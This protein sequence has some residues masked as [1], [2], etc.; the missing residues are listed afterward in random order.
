M[1]YPDYFALVDRHRSRD[2]DDVGA[3]GWT[4]STAVDADGA[5]HIGL[6]ERPT[7]GN[8]MAGFSRQSPPHELLGPL[9]EE[10]RPTKE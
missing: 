5:E 6:I 1:A 4:L 9:P 10:F 3:I 7:F 2:L 8:R